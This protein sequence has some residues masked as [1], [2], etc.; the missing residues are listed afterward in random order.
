MDLF[1][2]TGALGIEALSRGAQHATF[3]ESDREGIA[4]NVARGRTDIDCGCGGVEGRQRLSWS[5][6]ARNLVLVALLGCAAQVAAPPLPGIASG[7]TL[8]MAALAFFALFAAASQLAA[9]RPLL[10]ELA[11]RP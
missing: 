11:K 8:A 9:Q 6:V 5:L 4:V 1:A 3:V 2:G 7:A 10:N